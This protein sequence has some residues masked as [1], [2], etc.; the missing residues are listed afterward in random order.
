[1]N[2]RKETMSGMGMDEMVIA[3]IHNLDTE[4][5]RNHRQRHRFARRL[6][7]LLGQERV[8]VTFWQNFLE[9]HKN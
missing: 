5:H 2:T 7:Y 8:R 9:V 1:M 4:K 6:R 3:Q